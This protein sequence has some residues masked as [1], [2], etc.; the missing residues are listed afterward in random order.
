MA[1]IVTNKHNTA[2]DSKSKCNGISQQQQPPPPAAPGSPP[3][4]S[5]THKQKDK[6]RKGAFGL[7]WFGL[8]KDDEDDRKESHRK[9]EKHEKRERKER[10]REEKDESSSSSFLGAL[11]GKKKGHDEPSHPTAPRPTNGQ[12]TAGSLLERSEMYGKGGSVLLL[13]LPDPYRARGV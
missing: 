11:F 2:P 5:T 3:P 12:L 1:P 4:I 9:R 13:A 8:G 7:S 6:D 10:E